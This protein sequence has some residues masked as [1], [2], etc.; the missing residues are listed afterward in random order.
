V[1]PP[2][3][4]TLYTPV[5]SASIMHY[6]SSLFNFV[7]YLMLVLSCWVEIMY[8]LTNFRNHYYESVAVSKF[9]NRFKSE[10][11]L[12]ND[13]YVFVSDEFI[14]YFFTYYLIFDILHYYLLSTSHWRRKSHD[15]L[16]TYQSFCAGQELLNCQGTKTYGR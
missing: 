2:H 3:H 4:T 15:W 1:I 8:H 13:F 10:L 11:L 16:D 12:C 9:K 6:E 5:M 7:S 14:F